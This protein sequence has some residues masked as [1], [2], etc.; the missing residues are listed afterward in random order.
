MTTKYTLGIDPGLKGAISVLNSAT[1]EIINIFDIP[2]KKRSKSHKNQIN[3][4]ELARIIDDLSTK[5]HI[6]KAIIEHVHAMPSQGVTSSYNFGETVGIIKGIIAGNIIPLEEVASPVWKRYFFLL[7]KDKNA[8]ID[9]ASELFPKDT[10]RWTLKKHDG[11]C[12]SALIALYF[13]KINNG[14]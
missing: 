2:I 8:S 14:K 10:H 7:G 3:E 5:L 4:I 13:L 1:H 11:R 6:E 9:K 12:E